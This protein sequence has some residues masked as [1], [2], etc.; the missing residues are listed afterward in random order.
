MDQKL[1][2]ESGRRRDATGLNSA[3]VRL[4]ISELRSPRLLDN[5]QKLTNKLR[6]CCK[7]SQNGS[8]HLL[9]SKYDLERSKFS[10]LI[11]ISQ[12]ATALPG[13]MRGSLSGCSWKFKALSEQR[14]HRSGG[15]NGSSSPSKWRS[16]FLFREFVSK[17]AWH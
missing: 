3:P 2:A 13:H 16:P 17:S 15:E 14:T 6:K 1:I 8:C 7:K 11:E 9:A 5:S 4:G 12:L 10:R